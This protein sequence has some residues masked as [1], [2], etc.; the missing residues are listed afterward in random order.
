VGWVK[1]KR[2]VSHSLNKPRFEFFLGEILTF[3]HLMFDSVSNRIIEK[4]ETVE[5]KRKIGKSS[6]LTTFN[7]PKCFITNL[8]SNLTNKRVSVNRFLVEDN[9]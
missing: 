3:S 8:M 5:N 7:Q 4:E 2:L 6:S 1:W 9:I